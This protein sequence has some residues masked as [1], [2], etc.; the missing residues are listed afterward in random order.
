MGR[1]IDGKKHQ[2]A[3]VGIAPK[4]VMNVQE[5]NRQEH[6]LTEIQNI[7]VDKQTNKHN[8]VGRHWRQRHRGCRGHIPSNILVGG[9]SVGTGA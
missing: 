3:T 1:F 8:L 9:T 7:P 5:N 6:C 4:S 2:A